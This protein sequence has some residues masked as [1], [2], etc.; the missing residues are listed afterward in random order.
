MR[1]RIRA[2]LSAA[3]MRSGEYRG[4][5]HVGPV[6]AGGG[7]GV[8]TPGSG[9]R[10]S[11]PR[12]DR[13]SESRRSL[14]SVLAGRNLSPRQ[15]SSEPRR[16]PSCWSQLRRFRGGPDARILGAC[17]AQLAPGVG[18]AVGGRRRGERAVRWSPEDVRSAPR[19]NG[20]NPS[21]DG[22]LSAAFALTYPLSM[23]ISSCCA[24][25]RVELGLRW[26]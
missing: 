16:L 3:R 10:F 12:A 15:P 11:S 1:I 8:H 9:R 22:E 19:E 23:R 18:A 14:Q 25:C 5:W 21:L 6:T 17:P 24:A 13:S 20:S 2:P 7:G 4:M 26:I